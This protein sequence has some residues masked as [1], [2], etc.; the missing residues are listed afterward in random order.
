[1]KDFRTP[2]IVPLSKKYYS[3]LITPEYKSVRLSYLLQTMN[4]LKGAFDD[5]L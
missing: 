5:L 1:M 2:R 4:E 3:I